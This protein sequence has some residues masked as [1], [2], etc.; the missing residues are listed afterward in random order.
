MAATVE[1]EKIAPSKISASHQILFI[2]LMSIVRQTKIICF[3]LE[4]HKLLLKKD[5]KI[6][7]GISIISNTLIAQSY[8]IKSGR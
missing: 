8:P 2:E 3:I 7:T 5:S 1:L 4:Q 6:T